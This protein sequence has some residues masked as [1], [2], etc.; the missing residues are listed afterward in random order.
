MKNVTGHTLEWSMQSVSQYDTSLSSETG[1][2]AATQVNHDFW[3]FTPA[4]RS[5]RY[6]NRFHVRFGPAEN[7]AV[8]VRDDDLFAVHYVHMAAELWLDS[9]EGWLAVVDG[10]S[11]YAMIERFQYDSSKLYPGKASVIFWTNG[12][13]ARLNS[14]GVLSLSADPDASPYYLE[15]EI[16]SPLCRLRP[17]ESCIFETEWFPTRSGSEFHGA[18]DAGIL[19]RPLR[20]TVRENGKIGL[21]GSFGV[22]YSGRLLARLYDEHGHA[23]AA[24]PVAEVNPS[25]PVSLETEITSPGKSARLSIHLMDD[26]GVDR[27]ALQEV[28]LSAQDNH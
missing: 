19:I 14:E 2:G 6:L 9:T 3:T 26:S 15:A 7:P 1:S 10:K 28:Q 18:T 27:G 22:F 5:S 25:E 24:M 12:P 4:N 17:G 13:E 16:N 21:S 20:A 23:V 8:A 11:Q